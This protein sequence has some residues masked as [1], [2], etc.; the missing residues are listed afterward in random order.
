M[1]DREDLGL[2]KDRQAALGRAD[3]MEKS[4]EDEIRKEI[5]LKCEWGSIL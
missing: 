1:E 3:Y 5:K 2:Y 4:S